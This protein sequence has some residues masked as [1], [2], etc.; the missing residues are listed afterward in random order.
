MR[1]LA[2]IIITII[3]CAWI[4]F[5]TGGILIVT[6]GETS[7]VANAIL[8]FFAM[9]S[10]GVFIAMVWTLIII[11]REINKEDKDDISKY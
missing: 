5:Y 11:L 8:F 2:P 10:F 1:K 9:F 7:I 6:K 4:T 3:V